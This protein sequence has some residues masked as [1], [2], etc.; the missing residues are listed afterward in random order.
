MLA[1]IQARP[2]KRSVGMMGSTNSNISV[3]FS[4]CIMRHFLADR[5]GWLQRNRV[6]LESDRFARVKRR[7]ATT[8]PI[9]ADTAENTIIGHEA[10]TQEAAQLTLSSAQSGEHS[11]CDEPAAGARQ[12]G[13]ATRDDKDFTAQPDYCPP[14]NTLPHRINWLKIGWDGR[15]VDLRDDPHRHRLHPDEVMLAS[16]LRLDCATYLTSKRRIFERRLQCLHRGKIFRKTDAQQACRI[17]VNKASKLWT[18]FE[19]VGWLDE[20]YMRRFL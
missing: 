3:H 8:E 14:L 9:L 17:D 6:L 1:P 12:I 16:T 11:R 5:K 19:L 4:P 20:S 18:A 2:R 7:K 10:R 13:R 15:P